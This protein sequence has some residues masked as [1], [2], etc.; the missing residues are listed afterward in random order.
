MQG[1]MNDA[2]DVLKHYRGAHY[3]TEAELTGL[4]LQASEMREARTS[5][6]EL[7][8]YQKA[9]CITLGKNGFSIL[10]DLIIY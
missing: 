3:R 7:I 5:I 4:E 8:K 6:F 9:T 1:R 10:S 2:N